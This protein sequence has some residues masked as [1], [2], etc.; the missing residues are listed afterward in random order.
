MA[1]GLG[2]QARKRTCAAALLGAALEIVCLP[3]TWPWRCT[4]LATALTRGGLLKRKLGD[5]PACPPRNAC[6]P[7]ACSLRIK[8]QGFDDWGVR[9]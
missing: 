8:I 2:M 9:V 1:E 6:L 3:R 4:K 7:L 5:W